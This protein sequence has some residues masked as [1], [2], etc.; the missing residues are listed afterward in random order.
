M[1]ALLH[2]ICHRLVDLPLLSMGKT[3][4]CMNLLWAGQT[5]A[6]HRPM[7]LAGTGHR[8]EVVSLNHMVTADPLHT[9]AMQG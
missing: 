7:V 6:H 8:E 5:L 9:V 4:A 1:S 3:K 2:L